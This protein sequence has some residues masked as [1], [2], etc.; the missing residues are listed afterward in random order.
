MANVHAPANAAVARLKLFRA[1]LHLEV[2][3]QFTNLKS[4]QQRGDNFG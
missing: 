4:Y 3:M 2:Q 1:V